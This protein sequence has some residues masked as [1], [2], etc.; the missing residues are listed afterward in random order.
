MTTIYISAQILD[1]NLGD[2]W[3]DN[4]A[5][6]QALADFTRAQW[7][8]DTAE[9]VAAGHRIEIRIDVSSNTSGC[10]R[11]VSVDVRGDQDLAMDVESALTD[12]NLIWERF[13]QS[14]EAADL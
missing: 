14:A 2:G 8:S 10:S 12:E 11:G 4:G 9:F 13:C 3:K 1:G 6:A 5:T 7:E